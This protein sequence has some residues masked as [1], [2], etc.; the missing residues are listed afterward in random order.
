MGQ[1][2]WESRVGGIGVGVGGIGVG[3]GRVGG[4]TVE[5]IRCW[6]RSYRILPKLKHAMQNN[7][8]VRAKDQK[9]ERQKE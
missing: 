7:V 1:G 8:R 4:K 2:R 6:R 9:G 3:V 5:M